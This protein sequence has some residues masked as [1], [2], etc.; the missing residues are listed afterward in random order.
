MKALM[1]P[2]SFGDV[3]QAALGDRFGGHGSGFQLAAK[4]G[5]RARLSGHVRMTGSEWS[6]ASRFQSAVAKHGGRAGECL[7][8]AAAGRPVPAGRRPAAPDFS[9]MVLESIH[10]YQVTRTADRP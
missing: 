5:Q 2:V 9:A 1:R 6:V 4:V 7:R 10:G 8:A 3:R